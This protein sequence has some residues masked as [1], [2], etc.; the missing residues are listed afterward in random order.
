MFFCNTMKS[1]LLLL[2]LKRSIYRIV[3]FEYSRWMRRSK[4]VLYLQCFNMCVNIYICVIC[5]DNL[6]IDTFIGSFANGSQ[7]LLK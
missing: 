2:L 5:S 7:T 4:D 6:C 1:A 3:K